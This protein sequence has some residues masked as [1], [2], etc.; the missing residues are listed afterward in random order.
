LLTVA[1]LAVQMGASLEQRNDSAAARRLRDA[2]VDQQ[3]VLNYDSALVLLQSARRADARYFPAHYDYIELRQLRF[4]YP[5]LRDESAVLLR[6]ASPFD[7]CL[8]L[9]MAGAS[10][11]RSLYIE[12]LA[13]ERAGGAST[14]SA[15]LLAFER[16]RAGYSEAAR[17]ANFTRALGGAPEVARLWDEYVHL[18]AASR[19]W[20][21]V[22]RVLAAGQK[23][24]RDPAS[25]LSLARIDAQFRIARGDTAGSLA[26]RRSLRAAME[27]D[28]R[29][30]LRAR[31]SGN[32]CFRYAVPD[33]GDDQRSPFPPTRL[34][35]DWA[36]MAHTLLGCG[37]AALDRGE[38]L[39][40]L[41][42]LARIVPIA[43]SAR[44]PDLFLQL[45]LRR[46]RTN[47]K[48][49]RLAE[50]EHDLQKA[51]TLG[52]RAGRLYMVADAW[53]N[54]A[55]I[56]EGGGRWPA[57][58][59]AID[60]FVTLAR[61]MGGGLRLESLL[62]AGNI[63]WKAGKH[64]LAQTAFE[65]M[66]R[67]ADENNAERYWAGAYYERIGDLQRARA[68][69]AKAVTESGSNSRAQS[70]LA[71]VYEKLGHLD[72]AES[73]TRVHDAQQSLWTP[74]ELPLL[75]PL[76]AREGRTSEGLTIARTWAEHQ[77]QV[78][79]V[80]GATLAWLQVARL[81]L[82]A[83]STQATIAAAVRAESLGSLIHLVSERVQ[84]TTMHGSA[85]RQS[86]SA[87]GAV[88]VLRRATRL[89][90]DDSTTDDLLEAHTALGDALADGGYTSQALAEYNRAARAV[91]RVTG[92]LL[93]DVDRARYRDRN[94]LPFD[95][96]VRILVR[97][98][99]SPPRIGELVAW[100]ARRKAAALMLATH[101]SVGAA[102]DTAS[103]GAIQRRLGPSEAVLDYITVDSAVTVIV[104]TSGQVS[105]V[106]LPITKDSLRA[107]VERLRRPLAATSDGRIDL[108]RARFSLSTAATLHAA[109]LRPL[110]VS[111]IKKSRLLIVPDGV[112]HALPF[113]ALVSSS[114]AAGAAA[115]QYSTA[116][117]LIDDYEVEYLPSTS[118]LAARSRSAESLAGAR[119]LVVSYHA[120][121]AADEV[122]ALRGAW[123]PGLTMSL[124]D[125]GATERAARD[126]M[127][128]AGII[129]FAVHGQASARNPLASHL[130][131]APDGADVGSLSMSEIAAT[132]LVAR[133]VVLSACETDAGAIY[134]GEGVM[135]LA[136]AFLASG[137]EAVVGTQWPVGP[138]MAELMGEFYRR[139]GKG[140]NSSR[141]LRAAKLALRSNRATAH[142]FYWAAPVLVVGGRW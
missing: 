89:A 52:A 80:H 92:S 6:S 78:G 42:Y 128:K 36:W 61:P 116:R 83:R 130:R 26:L 67:A 10:E 88:T 4:E 58:N 56:Y 141:A 132:K 134:N 138:S 27:R 15:A 48:L 54:L 60:R 75:P 71:R 115:D 37:H 82:D 95:G 77:E 51:L 87:D 59:S 140:E 105:V 124:A 18:I 64:A 117:Y 106:R 85:L 28:G 121:G 40:A 9:A 70:G 142:P 8:G 126:A 111:L 1:L 32:E 102:R 31:Y 103:L 46:G 2:A 3:L 23:A 129:H 110:A 86:G 17:R 109:L 114:P 123:A 38:P 112:L 13:L 29:P 62:D 5:S 120:P 127:T 16:P 104:V 81:A 118:F 49:G 41:E 136:R 7:R 57:A 25:R 96:A 66:V 12:L 45:Y 108:A 113:E 107:M 50:A 68:Y 21:E 91:E 24:M 63:R 47:L 99:P 135:G 53:H 20:P 139:L 98:P 65:E 69:Y 90:R 79:N 34:P 11:Y 19:D 73:V 133:L 97:S 43:D 33:P 72:S 44:H 74:L 22:G 14:C 122:K 119:L 125:A 94:L 76:L 137:A 100:S 39:K 84:A 55:H 101:G 35:G 93:E 30:G 131:L